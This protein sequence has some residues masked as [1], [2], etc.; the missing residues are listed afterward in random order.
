[1]HITLKASGLLLVS[2][3]VRNILVYLCTYM[4]F[5]KQIAIVLPSEVSNNAFVCLT[6]LFSKLMM[7][8]KNFDHSL[9]KEAFFQYHPLSNWTLSLST[10][11]YKC[12]LLH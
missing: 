7:S 10:C 12:I 3:S 2:L 5:I 1:M 8:G 11:N 4:W 9:V 6:E